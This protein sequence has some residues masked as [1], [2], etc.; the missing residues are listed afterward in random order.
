MN[1]IPLRSRDAEAPLLNPVRMV[2]VALL[3]L[4]FIAILVSLVLS[5]S[6]YLRVPD[7]IV[8]AH[9]A[10]KAKPITPDDLLARL[11][12]SE[13]LASAPEGST[14]GATEKAGEA[15]KPAGGEKGAEAGKVA[16][17]GKSEAGKTESGK[18][19][20][21]A[22]PAEETRTAAA[23]KGE[24]PAG[25]REGEAAGSHKYSTEV[26]AMMRCGRAFNKLIGRDL[27]DQDAAAIEEFRA[28]FE[29]IAGASPDRGD[30]WAS[31]V[32]DFACAT[33][34][35]TEAA[36]VAKAGK[37]EDPLVTAIN[38]HIPR[39]DEARRKIHEFDAQE[40]RRVEAETIIEARR[41]E[42]ARAS[43]GNA[44]F[45]AAISFG[46]F[47]VLGIC[48]ILSGIEAA[49]WSLQ[50]SVNHLANRDFSVTPLPVTEVEP[51][52][53]AA[54]QPMHHPATTAKAAHAG[55]DQR[56]PTVSVDDL[57][58]T[59]PSDLEYQVPPEAMQP[60]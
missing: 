33:L 49:L 11:S 41:V 14:G 52:E 45:A 55:R 43:V 20:A 5:V 19:E 58:L 2:I 30:A 24:S 13:A 34:R 7:G 29:R 23:A 46:L 40:K 48:F 31:D 12:A 3:S 35:E 39:W 8:H 1:L 28:Q 22:K 57:S 4:A 18:T 53:A 56:E 60:R 50:S 6:R 15:A 44:L 51:I 26:R 59:D 42:E 17:A 37:L 47:L 21:G 32:S 9:K 16:E 10:P 36:R 27:P 54:Y 38:F 25:E